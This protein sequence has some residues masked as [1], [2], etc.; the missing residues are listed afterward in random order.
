MSKRNAKRWCSE[1]VRALFCRTCFVLLAGAAAAASLASCGKGPDIAPPEPRPVRSL[2]VGKGEVG[3]QVTLTGRIEARE[4]AALAFRIAGRIATND[5]KLGDRVEPGQLLARLDPQNEKNGLRM[6]QANLSAAQG[7]L[8]QAR[9]HFE[10]Q[11]ALLANGWTTR[12]RFEEAKEVL[13]TAQSGVDD[14]EARLDAARDLVSFTE[15]KADA[16]GALTEI[17]PRVGEVVRPGQMIAKIAR[18]G[19]RDAVFDVPAQLIHSAPSDPVIAVNLTEDPAVTTVGRVREIAPEA[20]QTRTFEVKVGLTDPPEAMRLGA[21]VNGRVSMATKTVIEI[22][23]A[24]LTEF[25]RQPAVWVVDPSSH[26]VSIRNVDVLQF[27]EDGVTLSQGLETG[28]IVVATG[29][30]ALHPGQKV[31]LLGSQP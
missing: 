15:L 16:P 5:L 21:T 6:A 25:D 30:Q 14:A 20:S 17:G 23:A 19:G 10:R 27:E 1:Y 31:R 13:Q 2:I 9:N 29:V 7:K 4:E 28:E 26:T 24:A 3:R 12:K 8:T 18:Q 22:P 11:E